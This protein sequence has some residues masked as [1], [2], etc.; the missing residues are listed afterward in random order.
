MR[1]GCGVYDLGFRAKLS[2][3]GRDRVRWLNGMITNNIREL[4][5]ERGVYAF[6]LNPQGRILGDLY[7][8]NRG[9]KFAVD[10]D[11]SQIEKILAVF[12]RYIIMDQVEITDDSEQITAI[13][14]S[15]PRS[16]AISQAAGINIPAMEALQLSTSQCTCQ[17][18]RLECTV[19]RREDAPHETYEI[20][21]AA[22][23]AVKLWQALVAGGAR[24]VGS[25][26]LEMQRVVAGIPAYGLDIRE[27][28]LPQETGQ[29][30]ALNFSKG[31][32][33]GQE[34]VERIRSRG[35]VHRTFTGFVFEGIARGAAGSK[36]V[37]GEKE[38][39]EITSA[40]SLSSGGNSERTVA[41]GYI[42]READTPGREVLVGGSKA[43]V[44]H[45]PLLPAQDEALVR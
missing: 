6:L 43:I 29:T 30:R 1:A 16:G 35:N 24:P 36:I 42:R 19:V 5:L 26:A 14:V 8:Y 37:T 23:D 25:E 31:C 32:Y 11:R 10:T 9:E 28:D 7:A 12:H 39:G 17:G 22:K 38:A 4:A 40:V 20:W 27:R 2:I 33:I 41:L 13:G 44:T 18:D 3:T 45:P 21:I 34:I 15:G